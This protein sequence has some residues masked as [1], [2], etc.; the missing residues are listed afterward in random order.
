MK[1]GRELDALIAE[2]VMGWTKR[3]IPDE[4]VGPEWY[5]CS[6][7]GPKQLV[8]SWRPSTE[9][10][11]AWMVVER[12]RGQHCCTKLYSDH[13]YVWECTLIKE[14]DDP[15]AGEQPLFGQAETAPLAIC[16]AALKAVGVE[17]EE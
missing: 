7:A 17:V 11:W 10:H 12:L 3:S 1:A 9:I 13:G 16:L 14:F 5:W 8:S 2:Q 6:E 4:I 15:H